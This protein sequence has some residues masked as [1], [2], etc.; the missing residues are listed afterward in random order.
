MVR[1]PPSPT[2]TA[3]LFPYTTL[4]RS[5][6][7]LFTAVAAFFSYR[8]SKDAKKTDKKTETNHGREPW[9]YLEMVLEVKELLHK[10]RSQQFQQVRTIEDMH[11]ALVDH[12][13]RKSTRLNS[14]H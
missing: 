8:A 7:A 12:T 6:T 9:E 4:F 1:P 3:T 13:D 11:E 14:S 10:V 2:R 5:F